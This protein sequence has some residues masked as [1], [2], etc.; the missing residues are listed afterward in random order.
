MEIAS[1]ENIGLWARLSQRWPMFSWCCTVISDIDVVILEADRTNER[2]TNDGGHDIGNL[3]RPY[4]P[5]ESIEHPNFNCEFKFASPVH[6]FVVHSLE[7]TLGLQSW[8]LFEY[9]TLRVTR[10]LWR[11]IDV[12]TFL[13]TLRRGVTRRLGSEIP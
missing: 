8:A 12:V 10:V 3:W 2:A 7:P 1:N 11:R 13:R 6:S 4:L 9:F 5:L